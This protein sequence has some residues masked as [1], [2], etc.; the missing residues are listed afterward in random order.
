MDIESNESGK[1]GKTR[2][3]SEEGYEWGA[4]YLLVG[5]IDFLVNVVLALY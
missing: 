4:S 1:G 5:A 3:H 2:E